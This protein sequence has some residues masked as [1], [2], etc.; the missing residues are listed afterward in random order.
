[1]KRLDEHTDAYLYKE[2]LEDYHC[3]LDLMT[4]QL[5]LDLRLE[6]LSTESRPK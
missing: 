1:M 4:K 3:R 2:Q 6:G 5:M